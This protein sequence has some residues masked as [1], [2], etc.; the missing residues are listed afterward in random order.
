MDSNASGIDAYGE[1]LQTFDCTETPESTTAVVQAIARIT[2]TDVGSLPPLTEVID[3]AA[4]NSLFEATREHDR[5][6]G[7]IT[8]EYCDY[9]ITVWA[10]GRGHVHAAPD[11]MPHSKQNRS[12]HQ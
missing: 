4:V 11:E 12:T 2:D 3:P 1:P 9:L 7:R 6:R 5:D 8:F 10:N